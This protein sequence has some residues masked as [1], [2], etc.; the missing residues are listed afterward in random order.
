MTM[1]FRKKALRCL[2]WDD[3]PPT[4]TV[5]W[6]V[7]KGGITGGNDPGLGS[8]VR[9]FIGLCPAAWRMSP[10]PHGLIGR[11]PTLATGDQRWRVPRTK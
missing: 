8:E 1:I 5:A 6:R 2:I 9:G 7:S 4:A 3:L 11:R 10:P